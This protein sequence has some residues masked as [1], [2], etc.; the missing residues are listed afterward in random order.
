VERDNAM[1]LSE[2]TVRVREVMETSSDGFPVI[3][4]DRE[5]VRAMVAASDRDAEDRLCAFGDRVVSVGDLAEQAVMAGC[6]PE[7]MAILVPAFEVLG[8]PSFGTMEWARA[9]AGYFPWLIV[10]G[11]LG[12]ELLINSKHNVMGP[13]FR[14]NATIGRAIRL[15]LM[16]LAGMKP[17]VDR[18]TISTAWKFAAVFAEDEAGSPWEPYHVSVGYAAAESTMTMVVGRHPRHFTHQLSNDPTA[19]VCSYA[20]EVNTIGHYSASRDPGDPLFGLHEPAAA[21]VRGLLMVVAEDHRGYFASAGWGRKDI[22]RNVQSAATREAG[23]LRAGGIRTFAEGKGDTERLCLVASPERVLVVSAGSGGGRGQI[24]MTFGEAVTKKIERPRAVR[25]RPVAG[26]VEPP[27]ALVN[28]YLERGLTDGHP[29]LPPSLAGLKAMIDAS[30]RAADE[31]AGGQFAFSDAIPTVRDVAL[32][33]LMAGAR[34]AYMPVILGALDLILERVVGLASTGSHWPTVLINGPVRTELGV[35]SWL[36]PGALANDTI[37]R[38]LL[39]TILNVGRF[40]PALLDKSAIG[41]A[42]KYNLAVLGENEEES[43]WEPLHVSMGF[44]RDQSTVMLLGDH[45]RLIVNTEATTPIELCQSLVSDISTIQRFDAPS[46]GTREAGQPTRLTSKGVAEPGGWA[47]SPGVTIYLGGGHRDIFRKA[48]WTRRQVQECIV[49]LNPGRT[50]GDI[51]RFGYDGGRILADQN[52][53]ELVPI[54]TRPDT[55]R[56]LAAGGPGGYS[57]L[58][59]NIFGGKFKLIDQPD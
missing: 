21:R 58:R 16:N 24:G 44:R 36:G 30:G 15:G 9:E 35:A 6:L 25:G 40:R 13:G 31:P 12:R 14:A 42:E 43:P 3:L 2:Y 56:I 26:R 37:G 4:P 20:D 48:R 27:V 49:S 53:A 59:T 7:Y 41:N 29:I 32:N 45:A 33:A 28:E 57:L 54:V 19:L 23:E 47:V 50:I 11:P 8:D 39:L 38:A 1:K 5:A 17:G 10:N 46:V 55:I 52:D 18:S 34:A 51:R 22:Q